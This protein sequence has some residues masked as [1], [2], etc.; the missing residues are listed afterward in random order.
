MILYVLGYGDFKIRLFFWNFEFFPFFGKT[1]ILTFFKNLFFDINFWKKLSTYS[2]YECLQLKNTKSTVNA[3]RNSAKKR[4]NLLRDLRMKL[5]LGPPPPI[6]FHHLRSARGAF[7][8]NMEAIPTSHFIRLHVTSNIIKPLPRAVLL[9]RHICIKP[10]LH[11]IIAWK[12]NDMIMINLLSTHITNIF[13]V[14]I[15]YAS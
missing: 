11:C 12:L 6:S 9:V 13:L 3:S 2:N 14:F 7:M 4:L 5:T 8:L 10:Q 1:D 15:K